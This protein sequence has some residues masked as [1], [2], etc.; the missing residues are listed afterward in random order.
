MNAIDI[1]R[2]ALFR[3]LTIIKNRENHLPVVDITATC[4][5]SLTQVRRRG[6]KGMAFGT[7]SHSERAG[8]N[9]LSPMHVSVDRSH[10]TNSPMVHL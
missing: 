8:L 9:A 5:R 3:R 4:M 7:Q 1:V 2:F 10:N 6:V